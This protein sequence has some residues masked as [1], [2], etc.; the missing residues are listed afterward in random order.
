MTD[1]LPVA[2][3]ARPWTH[4]GYAQQIVFGAGTVGRVGELLGAIGARRVGKFR[5]GGCAALGA[6]IFTFDWGRGDDL[7]RPIHHFGVRRLPQVGLGLQ[8]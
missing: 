5:F 2:D 6:R 8:R 7:V 4:T 1:P 3:G